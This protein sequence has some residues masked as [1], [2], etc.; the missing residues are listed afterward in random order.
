MLKLNEH[1]IFAIELLEAKLMFA[2]EIHNIAIDGDWIFMYPRGG[3]AAYSY[4]IST[5]EAFYTFENV[6]NVEK[7][8]ERYNAQ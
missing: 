8:F 1:I 4:R 3:W 7:L 2:I 5:Q 6:R